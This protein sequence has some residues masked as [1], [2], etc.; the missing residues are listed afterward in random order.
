MTTSEPY[1]DKRN[2]MTKLS[3]RQAALLE[4]VCLRRYQVRFSHYMGSF[5]PNE[6][7]TVYEDGQRGDRTF[8]A[9]TANALRDKGLVTFKSYAPSASEVKPTRAGLELFQASRKEQ[10]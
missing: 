1:I 7:V 3:T 9:I 4:R 5:Q 8:R 10:S 6:S 2:P